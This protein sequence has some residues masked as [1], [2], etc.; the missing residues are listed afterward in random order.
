MK[1]DTILLLFVCSIIFAAALY[2][3]PE[4]RATSFPPGQANNTINLTLLSTTTSNKTGSA[5]FV[6]SVSL[7]TLQLTT[8]AGTNVCSNIISASLDGVGWVN[9]A[10]QS[11]GTNS[12]TN[13]LTF[14]GRYSYIRASFGTTTNTTNTILYLGGRQ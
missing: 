1:K 9:I 12:L 10:T 5:F 11:Y 3:I 2:L 13:F 6:E 4:S 7:H 14:S 8:F